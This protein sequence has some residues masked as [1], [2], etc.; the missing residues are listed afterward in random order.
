MSEASVTLS[1]GPGIPKPGRPVSA[2]RTGW[3]K[4]SANRFA[5]AGLCVLV[6]FLLIAF[7]APLIAPFSPSKIDMMVPNLPAGTDH[8]VLGTD[9]LGRDIF[10]RLVYSS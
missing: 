1:D 4:F 10:S 5:L 6:F 7:A 3:K 2:W 8:H 9:D